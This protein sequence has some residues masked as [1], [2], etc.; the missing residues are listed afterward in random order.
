MTEHHAPSMILR[1]L[2]VL[3]PG[4]AAEGIDTWLEAA[5][6]A[7]LEPKVI[8]RE[9]GAEED[10]LAVVDV[11]VGHAED[12]GRYTT[13]VWTRTHHRYEISTNRVTGI[14][15]VYGVRPSDGTQPWRYFPLWEGTPDQMPAKYHDNPVH[16][17]TAEL[18]EDD[19]ELYVL[20][21]PDGTR[22][23]GVVFGMDSAFAAWTLGGLHLDEYE[24]DYY[25]IHGDL[26]K[27]SG[28]P[29]TSADLAE[30]VRHWEARDQEWD[31]RLAKP[32]I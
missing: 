14:T 12:G 21:T 17:V 3:Y 30:D 10:G 6:N 19:H 13:R 22:R 9:N 25:D 15:S 5:R 31:R 29:E 11:V 24:L 28:A 8:W 2:A 32:L 4:T 26:K 1:D 27:A 7:G 18:A 23:A 16:L 20:R